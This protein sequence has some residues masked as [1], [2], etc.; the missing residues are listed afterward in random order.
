MNFER[1]SKKIINF[2]A[3]FS[4]EFV[5][6]SIFTFKY[7]LKVI[8]LPHILEYQYKLGA[9]MD[10]KEKQRHYEHYHQQNMKG[11][12]LE[13]VVFKVVRIQNYCGK[14]DKKTPEHPLVHVG[15]GL[16]IFEYQN[17]F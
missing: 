14:S 9:K 10:I 15:V 16:D 11:K 4:F 5:F 8:Y 17:N 2:A 3:F 12:K 13:I 7:S 1:F 6:S